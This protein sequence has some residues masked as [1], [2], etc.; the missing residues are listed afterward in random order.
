M[1]I[2]IAI[3]AKQVP[4]PD[5]PTSRIKVNE[6]GTDLEIPEDVSPIV[7]GFDLNAT[8]AALK[9]RDDGLDVNITVIMI[10]NDFV[11]D[12][13]KKP[14]SM[15]ADNLVLVEDE[16]LTSLSPRVTVNILSKILTK[17]GP[18][19]LILAGRQASDFDNA[20]VPI[21]VAETMGMPIITYAR[22]IEIIK[23]HLKVERVTLSGYQIIESPMPVVVTVSNEIG[24]PRYPN[25]RG[26]MAATKKNPEFF[27]L[28]DLNFQDSLADR[29]YLK[30]MFVRENYNETEIIKGSDDAD[31]GR[32]LA[33]RLKEE[34]L[35]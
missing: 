30:R 10:G 2:E 25:L 17:M 13:V 15:G 34:G 8:E 20:H 7:N 18:F 9:L 16:N 31:A 14:I 4:D 32:K 6:S 12:V 21:G 28:N 24:E 29:V 27:S 33:I 19:D 3:L 1:P 11:N 22:K 35:L 5:I 23:E 26:I